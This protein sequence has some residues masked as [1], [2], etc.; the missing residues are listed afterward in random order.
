MAWLDTSPST[1]LPRLGFAHGSGAAYDISPAGIRDRRAARHAEWRRTGR[2]DPEG[3]TTMNP[4]TWTL[5]YRKPTA[6]RFQRVTN[7]SGT[8]SQAQELARSFAQA[9][10]ELQ[11]WYVPSAASEENGCEEDRGNVLTD[12]GRRVRIRET[13]SLTEAEL[14]MVPDAT[15]ARERFLARAY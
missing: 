15:E 3:P 5:A 8:W 10:P 11:V 6:N 4:T 2:S 1:L 12:T 7:W 14:A 13:G 9:H